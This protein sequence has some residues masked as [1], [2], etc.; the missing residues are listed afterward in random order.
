MLCETAERADMD[1]LKARVLM[2]LEYA[3]APETC[4]EATGL[5]QFECV[6]VAHQLLQ[7]EPGHGVP[8]ESWEWAVKV[9]AEHKAATG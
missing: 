1:E 9:D 4:E 2:W 8:R 3:A 5:T 6:W 7:G